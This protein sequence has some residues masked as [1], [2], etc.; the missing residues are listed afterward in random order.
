MEINS[1]TVLNWRY[2]FPIATSGNGEFAFTPNSSDVDGK[3][4]G[5]VSPFVTTTIANAD[6]LTAGRLEGSEYWVMT[7][8]KSASNISYTSAKT[9]G[10]ALILWN[11][12]TL[13]GDA[14]GPV[15]YTHLRAHET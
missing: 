14:S 7:T 10:D 4:Y 15:S 11:Y 12:G 13:D 6:F 9:G 2:Y 1:G 5:P 8:N 3:Y